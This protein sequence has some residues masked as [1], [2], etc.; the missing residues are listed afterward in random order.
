MAA[1]FIVSI[2]PQVGTA[3]GGEIPPPPPP[4]PPPP[5]LAADPPGPPRDV[6]IYNNQMLFECG[7]TG[8]AASAGFRVLFASDNP[9]PLVLICDPPMAKCLAEYFRKDYNAYSA[10]YNYSDT[11]L[12]AAKEFKKRQRKEA[13]TLPKFA[14]FFDSIEEL[15]MKVQETYLA[16]H[17]TYEIYDHDIGPLSSHQYRYWRTFLALVLHREATI[18]VGDGGL[19]TA[20][21][22][23]QKGVLQNISISSRTVRLHFSIA[24][25][26]MR[27]MKELKWYELPNLSAMGITFEEQEKCTDAHKQTQARSVVEK[28]RN[29]SLE[30]HVQK[31]TD[32]MDG[33]ETQLHEIYLSEGYQGVE[34]SDT[35]G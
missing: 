22:N 32:R 1:S 17:D 8:A 33:L 19:I 7:P 4:P 5:L 16:D 29:G 23:S 35:V 3:L 6:L 25:Q 30:N 24:G 2:A 18:S 9:A 12:L 21:G 34:P 14:E 10:G 31:L 15:C 13:D 26:N 27:P 20:T 11:I 28:R